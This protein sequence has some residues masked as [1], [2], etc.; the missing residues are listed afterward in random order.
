[1]DM[2][3]APIKNQWLD[4]ILFKSRHGDFQTIF[5]TTRLCSYT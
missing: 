5:A 4:S 2:D 1:M 3:K